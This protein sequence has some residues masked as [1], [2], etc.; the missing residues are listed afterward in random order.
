MAVREPHDVLLAPLTIS[1][2]L[3]PLLFSFIS[4]PFVAFFSLTYTS[5]FPRCQ[6]FISSS[7]PFVLPL[8]LAPPLRLRPLL[9]P[10]LSVR[11]LNSPLLILSRAS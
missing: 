7:F 5:S 3:S 8:L 10:P 9:A 11:A 6:L 1:L 4:L 2:F